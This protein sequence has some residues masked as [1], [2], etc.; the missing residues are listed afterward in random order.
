MHD[1]DW[2]PDPS[3]VHN[4]LKH[5]H[6]NSTLTIK[7]KKLSV[8]PKDPKAMGYPLLY[9]TGHHEFHWTDEEAAWLRSYLKAGGMLLADA[10]C[11]RLAFHLAFERRS[12]GFSPKTGSRRCPSITPC[13][14]PITTSRRCSTPRGWPKTLGP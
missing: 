11:G 7:F 6:N 13:T 12:P 3:A 14:T 9:M 5:V 1:G 10:C 4:L 8:R 2:D